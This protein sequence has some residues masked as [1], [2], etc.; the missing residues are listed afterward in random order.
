MAIK[1]EV[2]MVLTRVSNHTNFKKGA[3]VKLYQEVQPAEVGEEPTV[4]VWNLKQSS[5]LLRKW[6]RYKAPLLEFGIM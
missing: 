6:S 2:W 3:C 5:R 4:M 1:K